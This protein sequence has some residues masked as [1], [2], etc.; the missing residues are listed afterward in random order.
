MTHPVEK[1]WFRFGKQLSEYICRKTGHLD[2]CHILPDWRTM[3]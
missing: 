3:R 2:H 1:L